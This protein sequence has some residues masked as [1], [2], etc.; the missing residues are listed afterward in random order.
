[1]AIVP[2]VYTRGGYA[3]PTVWAEV[4]TGAAISVAP[5][6]LA[7]DLRLDPQTGKRVNLIGVGRGRIGSNIYLIDL[8]I[9]GFVFPQIPVAVVDDDQVPFLLGRLGL[10]TSAS[11]VFDPTTRSVTVGPPYYRRG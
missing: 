10:L 4:D 9:S 6:G 7:P 5:A 8:Q 1:V 11:I 2:V 3:S